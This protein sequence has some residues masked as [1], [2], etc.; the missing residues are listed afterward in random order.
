MNLLFFL[1]ST[2]KFATTLEPN[3]IL[4]GKCVPFFD[5][6]CKSFCRVIISGTQA[7]LKAS[8]EMF[9]V[10]FYLDWLGYGKSVISTTL[11]FFK[12]SPEGFLFLFQCF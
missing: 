4:I 12:Q 11:L 5:E 7:L 1:V 2:G 3:Q 6:S 9:C 8:E 10:N